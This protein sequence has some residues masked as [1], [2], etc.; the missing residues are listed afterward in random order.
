M[1]KDKHNY[2][3]EASSGGRGK[4]FCW[5]CWAMIAVI[6]QLF[7]PSPS[8]ATLNI[9][10][11]RESAIY[12]NM[13]K[14]YGS[15]SSLKVGQEDVFLAANRYYRG[16]VWFDLLQLPANANVL[17]V[18]IRWD[19]SIQTN[20]SDWIAVITTRV[21]SD[22]FGTWNQDSTAGKW[23]VDIGPSSAQM[24]FPKVDN[25]SLYVGNNI[26]VDLPYKEQVQDR[27]G[28]IL[29][30]LFEYGI[31]SP[32]DRIDLRLDIGNLSSV[33]DTWLVEMSDLRLI[34]DYEIVQPP[35][36]TPT[37]TFTATPTNTR[38][39]TPMPTYTPTKTWTPTPTPTNTP[40][41][42]PPQLSN[43]YVSPQ[44]GDANTSFYWYVDYYD[45]DGD[46]PST[47]HISI[48][49]DTSS[50]AMKLHS[51]T[52]SNGTYRYGPRTL[53]VGTDSFYFIFSD[54]KGHSTRLPV[55]EE[56]PGPTIRIDTPTFTPIPTWTQTST[57]TQIQQNTPTYTPSNTRTSTPTRTPVS[58]T[59]TPTP[60]NTPVVTY[61][62]TNTPTGYLAFF[63]LDDYGAVH[64]GGAANQCSLTGGPYFG[65]DIARAMDLIY[66][67]PTTNSSKL[68]VAVL[69]GFGA[70]HTYSS[71]RPP[72]NFYFY[73]TLGDIATDIA[74]FQ[75]DMNGLKGA[76][77]IFVLD[78]TGTL[79][80]AGEADW[81]VAQS[82][83]INP[84]LNGNTQRAVDL[85]LANNSGASGWIMDNMGKVYPFGGALDPTFPMSQKNNWVDLELVEGQLVRM[86]TSG[87][88]TWSGNPIA[89]WAFPM[90]D[91]GLMIDFEVEKGK[92][93]L[94]LDRFGAVYT[95]GNATKPKAGESPPY[96]GFEAALELEIDIAEME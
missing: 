72:Q 64:T 77:G 53:P 25:E 81:S 36:P 27:A 89:S 80:A 20:D 29:G 44:S 45:P 82:G 70:V 52:E 39:K 28:S 5:I 43:G 8:A 61:T 37:P 78:R 90:I 94:G 6:G 13:D 55:S 12:K 66:G 92:G 3:K 51:G 34:V 35:T 2:L 95:T 30:I 19:A 86:D 58:P 14:A 33:D 87:Q 96:F 41:N 31:T 17:S 9:T 54:G 48:G 23:Y 91:G 73:P 46:T 32:E 15:A 7:A 11:L 50:H 57:P 22:S 83:S 18:R 67:L 76:I 47:K 4:Y 60:T 84:P 42:D 56:Y 21:L 26:L 85:T 49:S 74:V 10:S 68:G 59:I 79:W 40:P 1:R 38:T 71:S 62:P 24:W 16:Y 69:D 88:L 93:L 65:W 75:V 63:V